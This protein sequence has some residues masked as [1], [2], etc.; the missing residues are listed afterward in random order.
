MGSTPEDKVRFYFDLFRARSDVYALR[1]ETAVT[2]DPV[3]CRPSAATG[4]RA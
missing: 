4:A 3:V 1:W 2:A